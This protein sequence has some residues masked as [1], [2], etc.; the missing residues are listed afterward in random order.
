MEISNREIA[1]LI[2]KA[3]MAGDINE[4]INGH[5]EKSGNII[6]GGVLA[7][8][9]RGSF[10]QQ[11]VKNLFQEWNTD[12]QL[13]FAVFV[14]DKTGISVERLQEIKRMPGTVKEIMKKLE[15]SNY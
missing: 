2:K 11:T 1:A 14:S 6:E 13:I 9:L 5:M 12:K 10:P 4:N 15:K 7:F 3:G 8:I